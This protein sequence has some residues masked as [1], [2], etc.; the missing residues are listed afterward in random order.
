MALYD[1][2]YS[3]S[4]ISRITG[5]SKTLVA[6]FVNRVLDI[7]EIEPRTPTGRP[8]ILSAQAVRVAIR[9]AISDREQTWEQLQLGMAEKV[10]MSTIKRTL[11]EHHI[12]KWKA[13]RRPLLEDSH[14]NKRLAFALKYRDWTPD[15]WRKVMFSDECSV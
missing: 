8:R 15:M 13:K 2:G 4:D 14:A 5:R 7:G 3:Y 6:N 11:R 12:K 1:L 9:S 10:S